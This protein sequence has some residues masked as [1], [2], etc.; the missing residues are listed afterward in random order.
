LELLIGWCFNWMTQLILWVAYTWITFCF[1]SWSQ[2]QWTCEDS[3]QW[4]ECSLDEQEAWREAAQDAEYCYH[5]QV[6]GDKS[7][8]STVVTVVDHWPTRPLTSIWRRNWSAIIAL[9]SK[10]KLVCILLITNY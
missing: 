7:E 8:Q 5:C 1:S 9:V 6:F 10:I 2:Q 3:R 4:L